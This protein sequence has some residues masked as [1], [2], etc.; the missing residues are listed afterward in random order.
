MEF[1]GRNSLAFNALGGLSNMR[2]IRDLGFNGHSLR[3]LHGISDLRELR[4]L[5]MGNLNFDSIRDSRT[6]NGV[7]DFNGFNAFGGGGG[8][9]DLTTL[10][11]MN[12]VDAINALRSLGVD[13]GVEGNRDMR[14]PRDPRNFDPRS[15]DLDNPN[16]NPN[17]NPSLNP[18]ISTRMMYQQMML[19]QQHQQQLIQRR[20]RLAALQ[21]AH[22]HGEPLS[23]HIHHPSHPTHSHN[24]I[25]R[26]S[27]SSLPR[28]PRDLPISSDAF[29]SR[30]HDRHDMRRRSSS[31]TAVGLA[32]RPI[33]EGLEKDKEKEKAKD[34][35]DKDK[36]KSKDSD[37]GDLVAFLDAVENPPSG[38]RAQDTPGLLR[39]SSSQS[40]ST[41][42]WPTTTA[43]EGSGP[44]TS[45]NPVSAPN[46]D[47]TSSSS[48]FVSE[49]NLPSGLSNSDTTWLDF[50]SSAPAPGN[51]LGG[52]GVPSTSDPSS[53][54][55]GPNSGFGSHI[56]HH[57][58]LGMNLNFR[59][60]D[61]FGVGNT[62]AFDRQML[63]DV[64]S[65]LN[66]TDN[67]AEPGSGSLSRSASGAGPGGSDRTVET[68][69]GGVGSLAGMHAIPTV[70]NIPNMSSI[71]IPMDL[72]LDMDMDGMGFGREPAVGGGMGMDRNIDKDEFNDAK[73]AETLPTMKKRRL[74]KE[75][76]KGKEREK[77]V[78][79]PDS[80]A[81]LT[82]GQGGNGDGGEGNEEKSGKSQRLKKLKKSKTVKSKFGSE[83]DR[84]SKTGVVSEREEREKDKD[85]KERSGSKIKLSKPELERREK[86]GGLVQEGK[87]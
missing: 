26:H 15:P 72:S 27:R 19:H 79:I 78:V 62:A 8:S 34:D 41:L 87:S 7:N 46:P 57:S 11:G 74:D 2:D 64:F 43:R 50:L 49:L 81:S 4:G 52:L 75:K 85:L 71:S 35:K 1:G 65:N 61:P 67:S 60:T 66:G 29:S 20:E 47:S 73:T 33:T 63:A 31:S 77:V 5:G 83:Q 40:G 28:D 84:S 23:P 13:L 59:G 86:D 80:P 22:A 30:D 18:A 39:R 24:S 44:S 51:A 68:S 37:I 32:G 38:S 42:E 76:D 58:P 70:P 17:M 6:F 9:I 3:D 48:A 55:R 69:F 36:N 10:R 21:A 14:D 82:D 16:M 53:W 56:A 12:R 25:H 54:S 45:L